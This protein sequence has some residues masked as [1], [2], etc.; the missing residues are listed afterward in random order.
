MTEKGLKESISIKQVFKSGATFWKYI[1]WMEL[2]FYLAWWESVF[3]QT[4]QTLL[5]TLVLHPASLICFK[6]CYILTPKD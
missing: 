6:R 4:K 5:K 3:W 1:D 2:N